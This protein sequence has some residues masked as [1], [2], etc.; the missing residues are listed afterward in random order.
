MKTV[1]PNRE[2]PHLWAHQTQEHARGSNVKFQGPAIYSYATIVA[3]LYEHKARGKLVL[4]SERTYSQTTSKHLGYIRRAVSHL[5][6]I[7][8]PHVTGSRYNN[9]PLRRAEHRAN[10]QFLT[11]QSAA[12]LARASR[13][14][15]VS[16]AGWA[17]EAARRLALNAQRYSDFFGLRFR[18]KEIPEEVTDAAIERARRI[19]HPDPASKDKRERASAQRK[20][21][22]AA[23]A[24]RIAAQ[25]RERDFY[26]IGAARSSWRLG[27]AWGTD[28]EAL[29]SS[30]CM[31]RVDGEEIE[32]SWSARVPVAAAP[33]VWEKVRQSIRAGGWENGTGSMT[34]FRR[35]LIGDYPLDRID[36]DGTLHAG[37]HTIPY[38]EL[39]AVAR[40]LGLA[41]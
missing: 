41:S 32:T 34:R 10:F 36:A 7:T 38:G 35:F 26:R 15:T 6:T 12:A 20:A 18:V 4:V 11:E 17:C 1:Y 37:C 28:Y 13:A 39:A 3:R 33:M 16:R 25:K 40:T 2:I 22:A 8:V 27:D 9:F 23:R 24:E 31:L 29:R 19:E 21:T 14:M 30:A 5:D